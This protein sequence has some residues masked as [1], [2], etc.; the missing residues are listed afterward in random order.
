M[1]RRK[2][3]RGLACRN[4]AKLGARGASS[5][6]S[7]PTR[8]TASRFTRRVMTPGRANCHV[9]MDWSNGIPLE[10]ARALDEAGYVSLLRQPISRHSFKRTAACCDRQFSQ[11]GTTSTLSADI[12]GTVTRRLGTLSC[13]VYCRGLWIRCA[14]AAA[15]DIATR[16]SCAAGCPRCASRPSRSLAKSATL[17]VFWRVSAHADAEPMKSYIRFRLTPRKFTCTSRLGNYAGVPRYITRGSVRHLT[18]TYLA[19]AYIRA[20]SRGRA[21]FAAT[22]FARSD[23]HKA[24]SNLGARAL[25]HRLNSLS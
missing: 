23:G 19:R 10:Q 4:I 13:L 7:S 25:R 18:P 15:D 5:A 12:S 16:P 14:R 3:S 1:W 20:R 9:R 2:Y 17:F 6:V 22:R 24:A 21:R 8:E 11:S